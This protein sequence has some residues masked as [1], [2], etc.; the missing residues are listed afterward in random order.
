MLVLLNIWV[1]FMTGVIGG[2]VFIC[3]WDWVIRD[4][5]KF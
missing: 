2:G 3:Y 1:G 5:D 4:D